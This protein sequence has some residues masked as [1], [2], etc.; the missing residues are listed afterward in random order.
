MA[1]LPPVTLG[2]IILSAYAA[3]LIVRTLFMRRIVLV[4]P[5]VAQPKRQFTLDFVLSLFAGVAAAV[6]NMAFLGFPVVSGLSLII[7]S[8]VVG[9][10][11]ALDT[12]LAR[13]RAV[14]S[15]A[16]ARDRYLPPPKRLYSMT[17][18]FALVAFTAALCVSLVI[19]LVIS[20]DV[21]WLATIGENPQAQLQAQMSVTYEIF[22]IVAI[23]LALVINLIISYS[24][25][26][27]M[28]FDNETNVLERV[29]QGDFSRLVPVAT[30]DEF[31]LIAGHT[32]NMIKGLQ[33]RIQ[34]LSALKLAEEVQQ[35][36]LPRRPPEY[37][38]LDLA[39]ASKYC[40]ETGGDYYDF[41]GLPEGKL[42]I[43]VADATD[44][45]VGSALQMATARAFLLFGVRN[46]QGPAQLIGEVNHYLTRDSQ[47]TSRFMSMFFLEI[48]SSAKTLRWV[49]AGHDP[50]LLY[51]PGEDSF[52]QLSGEG[53]VLG[54]EEDY[55]YREHKRN[56]WRPGMIIILGTDGI[57][58][59]QDSAGHM[60]GQERLQDVIREH[61]QEPAQSIQDA[62][63]AALEHFR[64][65][66][67]QQDDI[68]LV[69]IKFLH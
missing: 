13:E 50:A 33:H 5:A 61:A 69:V 64:G 30:Q 19:I 56:G 4:A 60:F 27:K 40:D 63:M 48:A 36:L 47:E 41:M 23:L 18:R 8:L 26:L 43:V 35:N 51:D 3:A 42:G 65:D 45:G 17:R 9:F 57:H 31:G 58:E 14:I 1:S 16:I 38:G 12:A 28:L 59:T 46:Y 44:H 6:W 25:N 29:S 24:R 55:Q 11:L 32:N 21:V 10:F 54:V 15:Q 39:G 62:V 52:Q 7:G 37:P 68:T 49:R 66:G 34:L 22:F 67:P 2:V 53:I 20:R